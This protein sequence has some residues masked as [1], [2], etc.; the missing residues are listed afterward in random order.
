ME[1]CKFFPPFLNYYYEEEFPWEHNKM[2]NSEY[3]PLDSQHRIQQYE[4]QTLSFFSLGDILF[5]ILFCTITVPGT[6]CDS[7]KTFPSEQRCAGCCLCEDLSQLSENKHSIFPSKI[8]SHGR[9]TF[10]VI[11]HY[12]NRTIIPFSLLS[13]HIDV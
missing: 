13:P 9:E 4:K 1:N 6:G 8:S 7:G 12:F 11:S 3:R 10:R 5:H 2:Q